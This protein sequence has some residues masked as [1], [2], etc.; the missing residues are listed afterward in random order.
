MR[1]KIG[2]LPAHAQQYIFGGSALQFV[3]FGEQNMDRQAAFGTPQQHLPIVLGKWVAAVH[4][5]YESPQAA[6]GLQI[7]GK[8]VLPFLLHGLGN[9]GKTVTGQVDQSRM[10]IHDEKVNLLGA[11][12]RF[13][14]AR[15]CPLVGN[16]IQCA[17]FT[18]VGTAGEGDFGAAVGRGQGRIGCAGEKPGLPERG[19]HRPILAQFAAVFWLTSH[20]LAGK[21]MASFSGDGL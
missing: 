21:K 18:G 7:L 1:M 6:S 4:Q 14:G 9:L 12:G 16:H 3:R 15:Q 20:G 5:L 11:A 13:T 17:G 19:V 2:Q 8:V 10:I